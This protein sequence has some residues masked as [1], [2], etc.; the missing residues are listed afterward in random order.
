[1]L[2][3]AAASVT[4]LLLCP[5]AHALGSAHLLRLCG[6][7]LASAVSGPGARA[8]HSRFLSD[9]LLSAALRPLPPTPPLPH[10]P[11]PRRLQP[12]R[13][14]R[15]PAVPPA[16]APWPAA[17]CC[18]R[19]RAQQTCAATECMSGV[20]ATQCV[21]RVS[22]HAHARARVAAPQHVPRALRRCVPQSQRVCGALQPC[23]PCGTDALG[24][25]CSQARCPDPFATLL[26]SCVLY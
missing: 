2:L 18:K 6:L 15:P 12:S 10:A 19:A 22:R 7:R 20:T 5:A 8:L 1:M 21:G 4:A 26:S 11:L 14:R 16:G 13:S 24:H 25:E 23:N 17:S 9:S 3:L